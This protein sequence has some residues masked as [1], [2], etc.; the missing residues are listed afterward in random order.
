MDASIWATSLLAVAFRWWW[1]FF[2]FFLPC[3]VTLWASKT[4][5][6]PACERFSYCLETSP[7]L[8]PRTGPPSLTLLCLFLSSIFCPISFQREWA[9]FLEAWC[10]LPPS[11]SCFVEVAQHSNDFLMN[12]W[13]RKWSPI[14]FL[15]PLNVSFLILLFCCGSSWGL[16][17]CVC[18]CPHGFPTIIEQK[19]ESRLFLWP[20]Q[21]G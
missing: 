14:L 15:C 5:H 6:R 19:A 10:P 11:G 13:G 3:Y 21:V 7:R 1:W 17:R 4:P 9:A 2:F 8:P 20:L 12:L 18:L 16:S